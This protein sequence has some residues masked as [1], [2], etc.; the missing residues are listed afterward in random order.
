MDAGDAA[1]PVTCM[2]YCATI[3]M[4]CTGANQ[5]YASSAECVTACNYFSTADADTGNTLLCH[6]EHANNAKATP[7]PHCWHAGPYGWGVCG[8]QC[9]DFCNLATNYCVPDAG[10]LPDSGAPPY[11]TLSD[12][13]TACAM[14][15]EVADSSTNI[16]V[17]DGGDAASSYNSMG[18][19][20]GNTLDCREWHLGNALQSTTLQQVH[21]PH[22][23]ADSGPCQ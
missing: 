4:A 18:P 2:T 11:A 17:S 3:Q 5:Q 19:G 10:F 15:A 1:G 7:N 6:N 16:V 20:S 22:P 13:K 21:C 8:A 14:F 12:C 23:G 9:D